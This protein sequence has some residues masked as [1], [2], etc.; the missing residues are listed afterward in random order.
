MMRYGVFGGAFDPP[1]LEHLNI[2]LNAI[3]ELSLDKLIILISNNAPHKNI[4][5]DFYKRLELVKVAFQGI[6]KIIIDEYESTN[7]EK[8]YTVNTLKYLKTKYSDDLIYIIGGDSL[9]NLYSWRDPD[10]IVKTTR[11]AVFSRGNLNKLRKN[12]KY[13]QDRGAKEII[14]M[15][16]TPKLVSSSDLRYKIKMGQL[17]KADLID[18]KVVEYILQNQIYLD[19]SKYLEIL[20]GTIDLKRFQHS[21]GVLKYALYLNKT[22][23]LNEDKVMQAALL[24]DNAKNDF[25]LSE[26]VNSEHFKIDKNFSRFV[27]SDGKISEVLHAYAGAY[28]AKEVYNISDEEV[29]SAIRYHSTGKPN[30]TMLEKLIYV[31]DFLELGR[32]YDLDEFRRITDENFENGFL[33]ILKFSYHFLNRTKKNIDIDTIDAY[34]Y[35]FKN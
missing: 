8:S 26:F 17:S 5:S 15:R 10:E 11:I 34:N 1:H 18:S 22:L 24:H 20:K 29:I 27:S 12:I 23:K 28:R 2:V 7:L 33:E 13:W 19:Y 25:I 9:E 3:D 30:M 16:Y 6:D 4:S 14:E 31:S 21:I 32:K 35:Y